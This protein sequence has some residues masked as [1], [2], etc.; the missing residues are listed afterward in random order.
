MSDNYL[1]GLSAASQKKKQE[2]LDKTEKAIAVLSSNRQKITIRSVAREAG[3]SVSYIYKYPELVYKIHKLKEQ[4]KYSLTVAQK[5]AMI[6][7]KQVEKLR[8]ENRQLR[9]KIVELEA[10]IERAKA[11]KNNLKDLRTE[12]IQLTT[13]NIQL[14]K[15]LEYTLDN[16]QSARQFILEQGSL[17]LER[18]EA[19]ENNKK[20]PKISDG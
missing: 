2:A 16:L 18:Q 20:V 4:Q 1:T 9:Q 10:V 8:E 17:N 13:E 11:V 15:E 12:N 19:T 7:E 3:V 6:D 14:K 5:A